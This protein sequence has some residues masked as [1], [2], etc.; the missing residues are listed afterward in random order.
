MAATWTAEQGWHDSDEPMTLTLDERGRIEW[1]SAAPCSCAHNSD[2][3]VTTT[4]CPT[5]A[6]EDP[7]YTM[8][9]VTGN[10]RHG[11][12]VGGVCTT[13]GWK[14]K[15]VLTCDMKRDCTQPVAMIDQSG[16]IYCEGHG[17]D[18]RV[19]EP[20]RR[21]RG[22]EVRRLEKGNPLTRY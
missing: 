2:G 7:C 15:R 11:S 14:A 17:L 3:T 16:F 6:P 9:S 22:W 4:M 1:Q 5:H 12:I 13:C 18:R 8:A 21:L 19:W 20:C 10:R